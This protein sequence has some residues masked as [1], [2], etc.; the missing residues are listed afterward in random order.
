MVKNVTTREPSGYLKRRTSSNDQEEPKRESLFTEDFYQTISKISIEDLIP[1]KKQAR[2]HFDHEKLL[3]LAQTIREH[4]LRQP[5]TVIPSE[6]AS[7]I[8]EVVS[9]ERRL[10]AAKL[11]GYDRVPCIII[12]DGKKAREISLIENLQREDLHPIEEGNAYKALLEEGICNSQLEISTRLGITESQVSEKIK[13]ASLPKEI[14][15]EIIENRITTRAE[16]RRIVNSEAED[17]MREAL[18]VIKNARTEAPIQSSRLRLNKSKLLEVK[19]IGNQIEVRR[20][21]LD[22][23]K[24]EIINMIHQTLISIAAEIKTHEG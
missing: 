11:A 17:E 14:T 1:Y 24:P 21:N 16:L 15:A 2:Q 18:R 5:L 19:L 3:N 20:G 7:G 23:I 10:R 12:H 13:L 22:H 8:Y 6:E 9:G 4:G